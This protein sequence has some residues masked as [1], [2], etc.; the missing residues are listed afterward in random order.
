MHQAVE[1]KETRRER[2]ASSTT[3]DSD[4]ITKFSIIKS[5]F[6]INNQF[7]NFQFPYNLCYFIFIFDNFALVNSLIIDH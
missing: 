1:E 2:E 5:Q 7:I 6:S 4:S 3:A